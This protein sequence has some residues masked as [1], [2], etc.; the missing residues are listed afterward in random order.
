MDLQP[1]FY[2]HTIYHHLAQAYFNMLCK[3]DFKLGLG[4][5]YFTYIVLKVV[6]VSGI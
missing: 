2:H 6:V 5:S 1:F 4:K 3:V